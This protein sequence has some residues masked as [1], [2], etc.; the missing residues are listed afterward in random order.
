MLRFG[1]CLKLA[2]SRT[3]CLFADYCKNWSD[4]EAAFPCGGEFV[5][6][7][8]W[9]NRYYDCPTDID[10]KWCLKQRVPYAV[11]NSGNETLIAELSWA[12]R[13]MIIIRSKDE[14]QIAN[15]TAAQHVWW[16]MKFGTAF[17]KQ[18][19]NHVYREWFQANA[20]LQRLGPDP[21]VTLPS[22]L[23]TSTTTPIRR[24]GFD[25][26]IELFFLS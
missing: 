14:H 4:R 20:T 6:C 23:M 21:S 16:I 9:C 8:L 3:I 15:L 18:A 19:L 13:I 25:L 24:Q 12:W 5:S 11:M 1:F 17:E 22:P 2:L 26:F 10:E 7:Y